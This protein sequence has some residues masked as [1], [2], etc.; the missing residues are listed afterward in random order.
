MPGMINIDGEVL[1][2]VDE[3]I[4][5]IDQNNRRGFL[6]EIKAALAE[7]EVLDSFV[8]EF[9]SKRAEVEEKFP[10]RRKS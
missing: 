1:A 10:Q 8:V 5:V 7:Q 4:D 9:E 2:G 6:H 3:A